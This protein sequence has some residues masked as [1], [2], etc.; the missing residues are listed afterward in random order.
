MWI[1][2][3]ILDIL[4]DKFFVFYYLFIDSLY[5]VYLSCYY[6]IYKYNKIKDGYGKRKNTRN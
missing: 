4:I 1:V 3:Y 2:L 6:S 5:F